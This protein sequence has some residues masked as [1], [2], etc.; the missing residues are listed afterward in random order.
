[1]SVPSKSLRSAHGD[2]ASRA[3]CAWPDGVPPHPPAGSAPPANWCGPRLRYPHRWRA[4]RQERRHRSRAGSGAPTRALPRTAPG[5][6]RPP[7]TPRWP[8]A[9]AAQVARSTPP[10]LRNIDHASR[11][12]SWMPLGAS[13]PDGHTLVPR[14]EPMAVSAARPFLGCTST[15]GGAPT[16]GILHVCSACRV[17]CGRHHP[18]LPR[19]AA[20]MATGRRGGTLDHTPPA[21]REARGRGRPGPRPTCS[22]PENGCGAYASGRIFWLNRKTFAG[23]YCCFTCTKRA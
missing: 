20:T 13:V 23:S 3:P 15:P 2:S 19:V 14:Q 17:A 9:N 21:H 6:H 12:H 18:R 22:R 1:M 5:S 11:A 4:T 10:R 8:C 16:S 7:Q